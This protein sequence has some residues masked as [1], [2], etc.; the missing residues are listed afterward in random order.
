MLYR[1]KQTQ[2]CL[3][4]VL[5]TKEPYIN[6]FTVHYNITLHQIIT[7]CTLTTRKDFTVHWESGQYLP[8]PNHSRSW[9]SFTQHTGYFRD[10]VYDYD[11]TLQSKAHTC[12]KTRKL[13]KAEILKLNNGLVSNFLLTSYSIIKHLFSSI[14]VHCSTPQLVQ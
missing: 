1:L 14:E 3:R 6:A 5:F 2:P 12:S 9:L 7:Y 13:F 11:Y 4:S 8:K 10:A